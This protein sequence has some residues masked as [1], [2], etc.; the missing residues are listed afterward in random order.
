MYLNRSRYSERPRRPFL[1]AAAP[2]DWDG[3]HLK[4]RERDEVIESLMET[5]RS[6]RQRVRLSVGG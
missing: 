6:I 2:T 3:V 4:A 1:R 5:N